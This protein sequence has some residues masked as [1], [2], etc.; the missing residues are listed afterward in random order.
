[1]LKIADI[2]T[3]WKSDKK[4]SD[5]DIFHIAL[6][7]GRKDYLITSISFI[8]M[9]IFIMASFYRNF[10]ACIIFELLVIWYCYEIL[11]DDVDF[12]MDKRSKLVELM[13]K[14][15]GRTLKC[16]KFNLTNIVELSFEEKDLKSGSQAAY[17]LQ[18]VTDTGFKVSLS[19]AWV[20]NQTVLDNLI[21]VKQNAN[22]FLE[23]FKEDTEN[24]IVL[25]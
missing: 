10:V 7:P 24:S 15:F 22:R 5:G 14:K 17:R 18:L 11:E 19:K 4:K 8:L 9:S 1:M 6:V 25:Q 20:L 12:V 21:L 3:V 16:Y 23:Q 13:H 2:K